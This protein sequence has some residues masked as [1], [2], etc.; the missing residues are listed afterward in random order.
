MISDAERFYDEFPVRMRRVAREAPEVPNAF[1]GLFQSV[2]KDGALSIGE[3]ELIALGIGMAIRC[4]PCIDAHVEKSIA[5]GATRKQV[6]EAAG[7]AVMM[8]GGPTY[9]YMPYVIEALDAVE[10][11]N[12]PVEQQEY[13][14]ADT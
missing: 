13:A 2:M 11:R 7:V 8:Q 4:L 14:H 12:E 5:A 9:T 10:A 1:G 3:K 6:L